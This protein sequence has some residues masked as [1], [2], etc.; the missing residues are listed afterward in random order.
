MIGSLR[1]FLAVF[2]F[3]VLGL[4]AASAE[5]TTDRD[6]ANSRQVRA[7]AIQDVDSFDYFIAP[8]FDGAPRPGQAFQAAA[9]LSP[10]YV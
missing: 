6:D 3:S 7:M 8:S 5:D 9:P 10:F 1:S 4:V 2:A